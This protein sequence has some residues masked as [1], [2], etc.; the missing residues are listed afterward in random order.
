MQFLG[1]LFISYDVFCLVAFYVSKSYQDIDGRLAR[2]TTVRPQIH[3]QT[4]RFGKKFKDSN[5]ETINS[6]IPYGTSPY[7]YASKALA[8]EYILKLKEEDYEEE[9][10]VVIQTAIKTQGFPV[11]W[12]ADQVRAFR[13]IKGAD[14]P[15]V[16][17]AVTERNPDGTVKAVHFQKSDGTWAEPAFVSE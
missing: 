12:S 11:D 15:Y 6:E 8:E 7:A 10:E 17:D 2:A 14:K 3:T 5:W 1:L 16:V 9:D 13:H 4:R